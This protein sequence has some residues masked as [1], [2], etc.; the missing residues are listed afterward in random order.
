MGLKDWRKQRKLRK[1][2]GIEALDHGIVKGKEAPDIDR[3][4][5]KSEVKY[6]GPM[7]EKE[8]YRFYMSL[9]GVTGNPRLR[10]VAEFR[11]WNA[12]RKQV[13][14]SAETDFKKSGDIPADLELSQAERNRL[15]E[16]TR[17]KMNQLNDRLGSRI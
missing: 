16:F 11:S 2:K 17:Q 6:W 4:Q 13:L 14:K 9:P 8:A 1:L 7:T 10:S 5:Q 3:W 12:K 15:G